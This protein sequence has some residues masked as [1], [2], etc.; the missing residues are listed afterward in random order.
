MKI[1]AL[2]PVL[3]V[4]AACSTHSDSEQAVEDKMLRTN[5]L[6]EAPPLAGAGAPITDHMLSQA[7]P[8]ADETAP[9]SAAPAPTRKLIY[10]ARVRVR[11][12]DL[13]QANARMDTLV[14]AYGAY[15]SESS[16]KR[17]DGE[18]AHS[19]EIRVLP[20]R[21]QAL[22]NN[23]SGLGTLE[24][25]LLG[26]DDVTSEHA[27]VAARLR[28]KRALEQR[29]IAL[30]GQAKKVS[31]ILEIEE[32]LGDVRGEIES[33]ESRLKTLNDQVA[34]STITLSYFQVIPLTAPDA[35]VLSFGSRLV[36]AFYDGWSLFT[37][38][39]LGLVS[40]WPLL[41]VAAASFWGIRTWWRRRR[42]NRV[43]AS[44]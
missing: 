25:K 37:D 24:S 1:S 18:W 35:P 4:L 31:E 32:K 27:D 14:R 33:V 2:L 5:E 19:M 23:L 13:A 20:T 34:Y 36:Q 39:L 43:Q 38:L 21:F 40:A 6:M 3:L 30:L 22:L 16:E 26:T 42:R 9:V 7:A 41:L 12:E 15:V 44:A 11:V 17:E 29:Y 8:D 10:H 28:T